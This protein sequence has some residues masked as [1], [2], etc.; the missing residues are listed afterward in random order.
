MLDAIDL[1]TTPPT[2]LQR[3]S[4]ISVKAQPLRA[5]VGPQ[6]DRISVAVELAESMAKEVK[7]AVTKLN[8]WLKSI[9]AC[10]DAPALDLAF[11]VEIHTGRGPG[12]LTCWRIQVYWTSLSTT[13]AT[14]VLLSLEPPSQN[15]AANEYVECN[16][17]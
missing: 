12:L 13:L 1:A 17:A 6:H 5:S 4:A 11:Y 10:L 2:V 9:K 16:M 8:F 14:W 15:D 3:S 7:S